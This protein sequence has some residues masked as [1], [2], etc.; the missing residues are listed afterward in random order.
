M[1][2]KYGTSN[3]TDQ[4]LRVKPGR[5][6]DNFLDYLHST[7]LD[8][9]IASVNNGEHHDVGYMITTPISPASSELQGFNVN[10]A[11]AI[12][13]D[14]KHRELTKKLIEGATNVIQTNM[15]QSGETQGALISNFSQSDPKL[16]ESLHFRELPEDDQD[17]NEN[18]EDMSLPIGASPPRSLFR[19][20]PT[21]MRPKTY[22]LPIS[23]HKQY[24]HLES[25]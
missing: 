11:L 13:T 19:R 21:S 20:A 24:G 23:Q 3:D 15:H 5:L 2:D 16:W 6:L 9:Y 4:L 12:I 18:F 1:V 17:T 8:I 22:V 25:V 7:P 14:P 10:E